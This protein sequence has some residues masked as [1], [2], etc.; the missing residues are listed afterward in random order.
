M[1]SPG[2]VFADTPDSDSHAVKQV[3]MSAL[4]HMYDPFS[5]DRLTGLHVPDNARCLVLGV[6]ASRV[7]GRLADLAPHGQVIATDTDHSH[8]IAHP[9]V[10][11]VTG[12][13]LT[14]PLPAGRW[15]V[16]HARLLLGHLDSRDD[17]LAD[18]TGTLTANGVIVVE[19]FAGTWSTSVL[20]A[21]DWDEANR[22]FTAYH[23]AFREILAGQGVDLTWARRVHGVMRRLGLRVETR[24]HAA[25]WAGN[26][27]GT[28]LAWASA[29]LLRDKLAAHGMPP[30]D[31]DAFRTLLQ[32]PDL[33]V[34]GNLALSTI[35]RRDH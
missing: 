6:G 25:T 32:H 23:H 15:D 30:A 5:V 12:D 19:E 27:P 24:A 10:R 34:L 28:R 20:D 3:M 18:L 21:P 2:Y 22:L 35:G 14:D 17:L 4:A 16:I 1:S 8:T 13:L 33:R 31:I 29:G 9:R 26:S 11:Q 7:A